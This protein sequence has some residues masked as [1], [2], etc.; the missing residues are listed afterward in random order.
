MPYVPVILPAYEGV[1]NAGR[2]TSLRCGGG[3][4]AMKLTKEEIP[5]SAG[6][7]GRVPIGD[8]K[9][10]QHTLVLLQIFGERCMGA[11]AFI[12]KAAFGAFPPK[13][14]AEGEVFGVEFG[15]EWHVVAIPCPNQVAIEVVHAKVASF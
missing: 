8:D 7:E 4:H 3:R 13:S 12:P 10:M 2:L 1:L 6:I 5:D 11:P 15:M 9:V 14:H